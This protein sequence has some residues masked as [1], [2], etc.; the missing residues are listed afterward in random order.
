[1][2]ANMLHC[3]EENDVTCYYKDSANR[4]ILLQKLIRLNLIS[5]FFKTFFLSF[6]FCLFS[7]S[8]NVAIPQQYVV[9]SS[10]T[11]RLGLIGNISTSKNKS[12]VSILWLQVGLLYFATV[13]QIDAGMLNCLFP[14]QHS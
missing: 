7:P 12:A 14:G 11:C 3:G 8:K 9:R 1:M 13:K 10:L 2:T 6:P 4:K 5:K